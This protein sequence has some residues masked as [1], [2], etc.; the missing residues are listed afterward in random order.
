[1]KKTK[2]GKTE[3]RL[4]VIAQ[5]VARLSTR[6][7]TLIAFTFQLAPGTDGAP[8]PRDRF[9]EI[10]REVQLLQAELNEIHQE[11]RSSFPSALQRAQ[12]WNLRV[13]GVTKIF[14]DDIPH[15]VILTGQQAMLL[16][17]HLPATKDYLKKLSVKFPVLSGLDF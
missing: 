3:K 10:L 16:L 15:D 2:K 4:D 9:V 7:E 11:A 12:R 13:G 14:A 1:M 6:L 5:E 17:A 8:N